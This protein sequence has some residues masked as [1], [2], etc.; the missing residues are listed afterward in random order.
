MS[1]YTNS[2]RSIQACSNAFNSWSSCTLNLVEIED[3]WPS[4]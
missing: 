3:D 4:V 2:Y 1:Q